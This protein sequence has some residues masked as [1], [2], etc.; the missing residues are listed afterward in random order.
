MVVLQ[1]NSS[2]KSQ[3]IRPVNWNG[4]DARTPK[5]AFRGFGFTG[6]KSGLID[7]T[8]YINQ[9][10]DEIIKAKP[11]LSIGGKQPSNLDVIYENPVQEGLNARNT[12]ID[13][14]SSSIFNS[15]KFLDTSMQ[16]D[17]EG[18]ADKTDQGNF[19]VSLPYLDS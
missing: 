4:L 18:I 14:Q 8:H 3:V 13:H 5:N 10:H 11:Y 2:R 6:N 1:G 9:K 19:V 12:A 15:S 7:V 17:I 16:A